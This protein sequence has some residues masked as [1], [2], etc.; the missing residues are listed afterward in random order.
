MERVANVKEIKDFFGMTLPE[1]KKEWINGG[2]T[3]AD[4]EQLA[5]GIGDGSFT[6]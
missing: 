5:K 1:M 4:K 6:Y 2:L 3:D